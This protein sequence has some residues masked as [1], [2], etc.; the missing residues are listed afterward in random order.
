LLDGIF[1]TDLASNNTIRENH[2]RDN[3]RYDCEDVTAGTGTAGTA[4]F[5]TDNHGH[6]ENRPGLCRHQSDDD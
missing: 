6:T 4:N 5:W 2:M 1:V 3:K